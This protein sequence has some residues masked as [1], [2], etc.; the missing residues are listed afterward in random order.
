MNKTNIYNI[1][2]TSI[3]PILFNIST[4]DYKLIL[5]PA[6]LF[7]LALLTGS[8]LFAIS[9]RQHKP[10]FSKR[11]ILIIIAISVAL[12]TSALSQAAFIINGIY[13]F[14][15]VMQLANAILFLVIGLYLYKYNYEQFNLSLHIISYIVLFSAIYGMIEAIQNYFTYGSLFVRI[16]SIYYNPIPAGTIWSM[17][18]FLPLTGKKLLDLALKAF[19]VAAIFLCQ[20]R[21]AWLSLALGLII[22]SLLYR[23]SIA[24]KYLSLKKWLRIALWGTLVL[25]LVTLLHIPMITDIITSRLCNISTGNSAEAY[26]VRTSHAAYLL[27]NFIHSNPIFIV[28]GHSVGSM[29]RLFRNSSLFEYSHYDIVDNS[30]LSLMYEYGLIMLI[31]IIYVLFAAIK[32]VFHK[33]RYMK[34]SNINNTTATYALMFICGSVIAFF[35]DIQLWMAP[36]L[37]MMLMTAAIIAPSQQK[38]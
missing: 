31:A 16:Y 23:D 28:I 33:I 9:I 4:F 3:I 24:D 37:L 17:C 29:G 25:F 19:Y 6:I 27:D 10:I 30:Y 18:I 5:P 14:N 35:Y 2:L 20:S 11:D 38:E 15:A 26:I 8:F 21:S 7:F 13:Y 22:Y 12:L 34:S 1:L 32:L 36:M